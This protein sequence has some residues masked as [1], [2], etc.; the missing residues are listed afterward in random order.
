M[1]WTVNVQTVV[2]QQVQRV[3]HVDARHIEVPGELRLR[4]RCAGLE[5]P[6]DDR[7]RLHR[8]NGLGHRWTAANQS[9]VRALEAGRCGPKSVTGQRLG[10]TYQ[11]TSR[12]LQM[13]QGRWPPRVGSGHLRIPYDPIANNKRMA[14]TPEPAGGALLFHC[15]TYHFSA[16]NTS[17]DS[18]RRPAGIRPGHAIRKGTRTI[19]S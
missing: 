2:P 6:L 3:T 10:R 14:L 7:V 5:V 18:Q 17:S 4:N 13:G 12:R 19:P 11:Q 9:Q 16:P 8:G 15:L 1:T